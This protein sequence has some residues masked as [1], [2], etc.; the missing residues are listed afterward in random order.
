MRSRYGVK[1]NVIGPV[2]T[3]T[4]VINPRK[5]IPT[6]N[7]D[8]GE[9]FGSFSA[10]KVSEISHTPTNIGNSS[11]KNPVI[12]SR[13]V[14]DVEMNSCIG[15]CLCG[16]KQIANNATAKYPITGRNGIFVRIEPIKSEPMQE[17]PMSRT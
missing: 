1:I 10:L 3:A 11:V 13:I 12:N 5:N 2:V 9:L 7:I 14:L 17:N 6:A 8:S 15:G 4:N 16:A